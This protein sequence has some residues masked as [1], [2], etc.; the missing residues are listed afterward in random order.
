MSYTRT[1]VIFPFDGDQEIEIEVKLQ[2]AEPDVGIMGDYIDDWNVVSVQNDISPVACAEMNQR[3]SETFGDEGII[4][5][6]YEA[7]AE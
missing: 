2:S 5:K 4:E 1:A 3:L 6:L 7:I